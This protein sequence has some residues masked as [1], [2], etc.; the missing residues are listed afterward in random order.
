MPRIASAKKA[1]RQNVRR[2]TRNLERQKNLKTA[3]KDYRKL[4][5]GNKTEEAKRYLSSV[6]KT[7]DKMAKVGFIKTGRANRLKSR[8]SKKLKTDKK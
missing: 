1:L 8:L 7:L 5:T 3:L 4:L 6:Y 2:R